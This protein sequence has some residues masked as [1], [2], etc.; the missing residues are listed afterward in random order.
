[1]RSAKVGVGEAVKDGEPGLLRGAFRA[2]RST[3]GLDR[4]ALPYPLGNDIC[5]RHEAD[6]LL[7]DF[8]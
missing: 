4:I 8:L 7:L 1:M 5:L 2:G 3:A 6:D